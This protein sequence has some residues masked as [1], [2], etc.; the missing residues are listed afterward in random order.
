LASVHFAG[1]EIGVHDQFAPFHGRA[2]GES[3][4]FAAHACTIIS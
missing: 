1:A 3:L 4:G 2:E